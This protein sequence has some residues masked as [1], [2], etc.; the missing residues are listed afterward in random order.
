MGIFPELNQP[1][2]D[3]QLWKPP[4]LEH[5][6]PPRSVGPSHPPPKGRFRA[7]VRKVQV[8]EKWSSASLLEQPETKIALESYGGFLKWGIPKIVGLSGKI[9]LKWMIWGYPDFGKPPY[10]FEQDFSLSN[11]RGCPQLVFRFF[12]FHAQ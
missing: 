11:L 12:M 2:L 7:L 6:P 1:F 5:F 9:L 4:M 8:N 3:T 10:L